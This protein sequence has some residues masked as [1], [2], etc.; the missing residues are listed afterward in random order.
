MSV[1]FL[2]N[3]RDMHLPSKD[4]LEESHTSSWS[5]NVKLIIH[6]ADNHDQAYAIYHLIS[7]AFMILIC[8]YACNRF[9]GRSDAT[10]VWTR[11]SGGAAGSPGIGGS[12]GRRIQ[13][14]RSSWVSWSPTF[15]ISK[16]QAPEHSKP[17]MFSKYQLES[18]YVDALSTKGWLEPLATYTFLV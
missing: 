15:L 13:C 16:R 9:P 3:R 7:Y 4:Q 8:A 18:F 12:G 11:A 10:R 5:M 6:L 2:Y 17:P 14:G 1:C